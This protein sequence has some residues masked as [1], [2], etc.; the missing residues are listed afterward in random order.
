[1]AIHNL[2][3]ANVVWA[4][5][6]AE[7]HYLLASNRTIVAPI[8]NG[9][10]REYFGSELNPFNIL[11]AL[12]PPLAAL[13]VNEAVIRSVAFIGMA[14]LLTDHLLVRARERI[15]I[16]AL[17][18]GGYCLLPFIFA[19][20]LSTAGVPL[21]TWAYLNAR[22]SGMTPVGIAIIIVIAAYS[23]FASMGMF[24][25][26]IL[27]VVSLCDAQARRY[28]AARNTVLFMLIMLGASLIAEYRLF[29]LLVSGDALKSQRNG[30]HPVDLSLLQSIRAMGVLFVRGVDE[31]WP[32]S[33][34]IIISTCGLVIALPRKFSGRPESIALLKRLRWLLIAIV[35]ISF[36]YGFWQ[37]SALQNLA[38]SAHIPYVNLSRFYR[39]EPPL[40]HVAFAMA[41]AVIAARQDWPQ[42]ARYAVIVAAGVAQ[43]A[44]GFWNLDVFAEA[45]SSGL[46]YR[47]FYASGLFARI[48][49][50]IGL[51]PASYR[52]VS[53][54]LHPTIAQYNGFYT[55]DGYQA[56]YPKSYKQQFR[57]IIAPELKK[58]DELRHY[59]DDWGSRVY[60]FSKELKPCNF[61]CTRNSA[62]SEISL[63]FDDKAF[64]GMG[65]RFVFSV[66]KIAN[67]DAL[68]LHLIKAYDQ[69]QDAW[70]L[71]L[72]GLSAG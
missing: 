28:A 72:Y 46:S 39:L 31:A 10:P 54:G 47:Q 41:L 49:R 26:L 64:R 65:G 21:L 45:R 37:Y 70:R 23:F 56:I 60:V 14:L 1:M 51:P 30:M 16:S 29:F 53:V 71:Y 15:L 61:L 6:L 8:L 17:V 27:A 34:P 35:A 32:L 38:R 57:H 25:I 11:F 7:D 33:A 44:L 66:S 42:K 3:E 13:I 9:I 4:K 36:V 55:L 24:Y 12:F 68:H 48:Q 18:A 50:D 40:W 59:Y 62:P 20:G 63:G 43:I 52:V 69:P 2:L 22:R 58:D 67:A 19:S 5:V